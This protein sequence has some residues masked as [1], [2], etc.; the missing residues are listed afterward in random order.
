MLVGSCKFILCGHFSEKILRYHLQWGQ[1]VQ[2]KVEG[3]RG[4]EGSLQPSPVLFNWKSTNMRFYM[5]ICYLL[6]AIYFV[7]SHA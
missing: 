7:E 4:G 5:F 1:G 3:M 6:Y 2:S